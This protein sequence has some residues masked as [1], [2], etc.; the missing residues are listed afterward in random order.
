MQDGIKL[1]SYGK[2]LISL[3]TIKVTYFPQ[4]PLGNYF[5]WSLIDGEPDDCLLLFLVHVGFA[6]FSRIP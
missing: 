2:P 5:D 1:L 3:V 4:Y 6:S